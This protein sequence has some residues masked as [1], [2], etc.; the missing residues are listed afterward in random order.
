M[1]CH[2]GQA[3]TF[4][5][6]TLYECGIMTKLLVLSVRKSKISLSHS[7]VMMV[8]EKFLTI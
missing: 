4:L 6:D 1:F 5:N 2:L 3:M 7:G 8:N